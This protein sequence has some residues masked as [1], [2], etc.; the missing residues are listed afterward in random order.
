VS[1]W[2][3]QATARAGVTGDQRLGVDQILQRLDPVLA[4][5]RTV[6]NL[7]AEPPGFGPPG[8]V[9]VVGAHYDTHHDQTGLRG[10]Q[11]RERKE[12]V[13]ARAS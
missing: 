4:E 12:R 10:R 3:A 1:P 2:I 13:A 8:Q 7:E 6:S 5:G 9:L 11:C